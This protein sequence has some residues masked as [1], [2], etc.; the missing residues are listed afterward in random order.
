MEL[1]NFT[2]KKWDKPAPPERILIIRLHAIGD[3]A[4][5][6]PACN[7]LRKKYPGAIIDY[8]TSEQSVPMLRA[9]GIFDNVFAFRNFSSLGMKYDSLK[10]RLDKLKEIKK[11]GVALKKNNY[12]IVVDLQRNRASR[13]MR[14]FSGGEYYSEFD[15]LSPNAASLRT[16]ETFRRA[17]FENIVNNCHLDLEPELLSRA[18][19]ILLK[20]GW[21][22]RSKLIVLNPAGLWK[23]RNWPIDNY[24]ELAKLI[25]GDGEYS[26]LILGDDRIKEKAEYLQEKTGKNLINLAGKTKLDEAL[27]IFQLV[28]ATV[29]EDSAIIHISWASGAPTLALLGSTRSDWTMPQPPHGASLN[30]SDLEC[31]NCMDEVCKFGDVHCLTRFTPEM[32]YEKLTEIVK[33]SSSS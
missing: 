6:I 18:K 24:A 16:L 32:V 26:F 22:G 23:T 2:F 33:G 13:L 20:N 5:T 29:S 30:S 27:G 1:E 4:L 14:F 11:W 25:S 31:G 3:T 19:Q 15:R 9:I 8:I 28:W 21:D 12:D 10:A 7:S 17:G